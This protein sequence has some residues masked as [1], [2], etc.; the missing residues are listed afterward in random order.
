MTE[1]DST[2]IPPVLPEASQPDAAT[3]P[4]RTWREGFTFSGTGG[5]YFGIWI[6][7]I[8]LT[9]LTLGIYS[10]WAKVRTMQYF[11]RNTRLAGAGFDYHGNPIAILKGRLLAVVL[12]GSYSVAGMVSPIAAVV[13]FAM[14]VCVLPW[15]LN[16]SLRFRA[17][18]TSYRGLRLR[19]TGTTADAYKVFL[20]FPLAAALTLGGLLPL[21]QQRM[22]QYLHSNASYGHTPFSFD[23]TV[24]SFYRVYLAALGLLL[25]L[26]LVAAVVVGGSFAGALRGGTESPGATIGVVLGML[27]AFVLYMS[28]SMAIW[29]FITARVQNLAWN[30]TRVGPHRF[31]SAIKAR[32]LAF[33]TV[34]N[35]LGLIVTLGL[36]K[37]FAEVRLNEYLLSVTAVVVSGNLSDFVAAEQLEVSAA[38]EELVDMFDFDIAI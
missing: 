35:L 37:P 10:A 21:W 26:I 2:L 7:N 1:L 27:A 14:L 9:V 29:A 24:G 38:G 18:N 33:I 15:L 11:Y 4:V 17:H 16:R 3:A 5:E 22:K 36:F 23:A 13:V 30:G 8:L 20:L 25:A 19:F 32:Q 31:E 6:V 12:F 34:T 28:G